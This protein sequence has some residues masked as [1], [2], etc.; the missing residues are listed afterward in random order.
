LPSGCLPADPDRSHTAPQG[1]RS[2]NEYRGDVNAEVILAIADALVAKRGPDGRV[3]K[4]GKGESFLG[5]G[6]NDVGLDDN[7]QDCGKGVN[8]TFHDSEGHPLVNRARFPDMAGMV[9]SIQRHGFKVGF[10][11]NNCI[12]QEHDPTRQLWSGGTSHYKGDVNATVAFGFDSVK[13]DG[14]GDFMDLHLWYKL[15]SAQRPVMIENCHWG[16]E[17]P[18]V[19]DCPYHMFRTSGD[20]VANW[21]QMFSNLQSTR[22][23]QDAAA[24]VS[25]PGCWA[26]P[27]MLEVGRMLEPGGDR[28][29]F[30]AWVITSAPLILGH[31]ATDDETNA[32]IWPLVSNK[33]AI[34]INQGW[35]GHPGGLVHEEHGLQVWAKVLPRGAVAVFVI[36]NNTLPGTDTISVPFKTVGL[37][38]GASYIVTNVLTRV[39]GLGARSSGM[40][41]NNAIDLDVPRH[42]GALLHVTPGKD[43]PPVLLK[44][45]KFLPPQRNNVAEQKR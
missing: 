15:F 6:Y 40:S 21:G 32:K 38:D 44:A 20:I 42:D 12:C 4:D 3:S 7:W 31:R 26:Y 39:D 43:A 2:W 27:D 41:S 22:K 11:L 16:N 13:L 1:W 19:S 25:R 5:L 34:E 18:T 45:L 35:A 24:P 37:A 23:F 8:G 17:V 30:G 29:H 10:Y 36:N 9:R 14:C 28:A 33:L